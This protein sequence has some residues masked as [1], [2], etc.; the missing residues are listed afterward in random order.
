MRRMTVSVLRLK[1]VLARWTDLQRNGNP[2]DTTPGPGGP[3]TSADTPFGYAGD[4]SFSTLGGPGTGNST[5]WH[6]SFGV[7]PYRAVVDGTSAVSVSTWLKY[8]DADLTIA[9]SQTTTSGNNTNNN[10]N[11]FFAMTLDGGFGGSGFYMN[12][13]TGTD[14]STGQ[15]GASNKNKLSVI[16]TSIATDAEQRYFTTGTLTPGAWNHIVA[17]LD[18]ANDQIRVSINGGAFETAN[19]NFGSNTFVAGSTVGTTPDIIPARSANAE[20]IGLLDE[21]A[22]WTSA[23]SEDNVAW[24]QQNSLHDLVPVPE[25][26]VFFLAMFT[27]VP[28][29]S[30][31][32]ISSQNLERTIIEMAQPEGWIEAFRMTILVRSPRMELAAIRRNRSAC[33]NALRPRYRCARRSSL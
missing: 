5:I 31:A 14:G 4:S 1:I 33:M 6:G 21:V 3:T 9:G 16:G 8:Q 23:L 26:S 11:A 30:R 32:Q 25:P 20:Y 24:L 17:I 22:I 18:A 12:L 13:P 19:V 27:C 2:S 28:F 15:S 7:G 29:L 10:A